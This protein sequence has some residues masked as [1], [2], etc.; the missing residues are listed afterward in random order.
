M[1]ERVFLFYRRLFINSRLS[2]ENVRIYAFKINDSVLMV[3]LFAEHRWWFFFNKKK[4][5]IKFFTFYLLLEGNQANFAWE[6]N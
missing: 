5:I 2:T 6:I 3:F 4:H 1:R